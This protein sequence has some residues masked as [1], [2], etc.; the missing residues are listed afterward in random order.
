MRT[1]L[2]TEV[3]QRYRYNDDIFQQL[4]QYYNYHILQKSLGET[5]VPYSLD[6]CNAS[7]SGLFPN[8]A[9]KHFRSLELETWAWVTIPLTGP[10]P[11]V[12]G[13]MDFLKMQ[14][15]K[16]YKGT[17]KCLVRNICNVIITKLQ[18]AYQ[19][20][21]FFPL[22]N[23][24]WAENEKLLLYIKSPITIS[25][26]RTPESCCASKPSSQPLSAGP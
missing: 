7:R 6:K 26:S 19:P 22:S 4:E 1:V 21:C 10:C 11:L 12:F 24:L 13:C 14:K 5:S 20:R 25:T 18:V 16:P 2:N 3:Q 15:K 8:R 23:D 9:K 17:S